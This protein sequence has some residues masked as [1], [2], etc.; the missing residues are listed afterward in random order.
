MSGLR[1]LKKE[2]TRQAISDT[3]ITMFLTKGFDQV[4]VADVAAAAEVSK[5]TLFRYFS[6]KEDLVLHRAADHFGES[7]RIVRERPPGE[8]PLAA[9][10]RH[11]QRGLDEHDPVTGLCD[12][13]DVLAYHR[14]VFETPSIA[15]RLVEVTAEDTAALTE[16]L[17][18][19]AD[20]K[21]LPRLVATQYTVVRQILARE[22]WTKL[23]TGRT[24]ADVHPEATAAADAAF[25][26]LARGATPHGY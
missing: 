24:A 3:A 8:A 26:L 19:A 11:F 1:D 6:S 14:L 9:L 18:E 10:H 12:S 25:S 2:R 7:A 4:A 23:A 5:P 21:L 17:R 13:P 22:N 16:A 15:A 20:D